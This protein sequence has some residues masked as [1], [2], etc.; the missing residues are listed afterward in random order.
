LVTRGRRVIF[1]AH[2]RELITQASRKLHAAGI[3]AG[4][5]LPGFPMRLAEPVQVASVASL[6]ARA[7]RS[8]SME[9]PPA[10]LVIV[11]ECHHVRAR[12]YRQI[13]AAFPNANILGLT[14]TPCRGDGR[15][16]G[17]VF[18]TLIEAPD[19]A[20]LTASGYLVPARVYAPS[21]PD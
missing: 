21:Q 9:M 17:A 1:L 15:G 10:D 13:L 18:G 3:D 14:A 16:L 6:H 8:D 7:I 20:E 5:I 11:D 19:V 12:T 2:R 4:I